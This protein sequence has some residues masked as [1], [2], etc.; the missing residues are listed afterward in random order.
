MKSNKENKS[1][2][3]NP[4]D[5]EMERQEMGAKYGGKTGK[6][7]ARTENE[8]MDERSKSSA[9]NS[10]DGVRRSSQKLGQS[11][12]SQKFGNKDDNQSTSDVNRKNV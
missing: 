11:M 10:D 3:V 12:G 1:N 5:N 7:E 8:E 9:P 6:S 4:L 2:K